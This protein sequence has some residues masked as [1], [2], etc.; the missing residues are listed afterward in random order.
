MG[1]PVISPDSLPYLRLA[2][3]WLYV[4]AFS[5]RKRESP[6]WA[7]DRSGSV[8]ARTNSRSA[9]AANVHQVLAPLMSQPPSVR[10]ALVVSAATSD[11]Q[12]GSVTAI[13]HKTSPLA[14]GGSHEER[15]ASV[16]PSRSARDRMFG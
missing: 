3:P 13:A 6:R 2:K 5:T 10:V 8:R 11:P 16:L 4:G 9:R 1:R 7:S 12:S 15:C 14:T